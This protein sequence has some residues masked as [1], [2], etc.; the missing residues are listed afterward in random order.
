MVFATIDCE[1][2]VPLCRRYGITGLPTVF[3]FPPLSTPDTQPALYEGSTSSVPKA[4]EALDQI[5]ERIGNPAVPQLKQLTGKDSFFK[6][7]FR[8][9]SSPNSPRWLRLVRPAS[10]SQV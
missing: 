9:I 8:T 2:N 10:D 3:V 5:Y 1:H 7:C 4:V 6:H